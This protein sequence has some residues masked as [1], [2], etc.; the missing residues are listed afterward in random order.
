MS[1]NEMRSF[2][3]LHVPTDSCARQGPLLL[4]RRQGQREM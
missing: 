4:C 2:I 1:G 3:L